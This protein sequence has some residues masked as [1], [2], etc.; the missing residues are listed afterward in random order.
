MALCRHMHISRQWKGAQQ[1][2]CG[3]SYLVAGRQASCRLCACL[4]V[5]VAGEPL[6]L[7]FQALLNL[8]LRGQAAH[9]LILLLRQLVYVLLQRLEAP[10]YQQMCMSDPL[11]PPEHTPSLACTSGSARPCGQRPSG[12]LNPALFSEQIAAP[13]STIPG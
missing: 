2:A 10:V 7:L 9:E 1:R 3:I 6:A 4:A 12:P 11:R 8:A 13:C 5:E